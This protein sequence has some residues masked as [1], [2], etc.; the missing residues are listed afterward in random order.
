MSACLIDLKRS[1]GGWNR[2]IFSR[3]FVS[4]LLFVL[5]SYRST[6]PQFMLITQLETHIYRTGKSDMGHMKGDISF[7]VKKVTK[8]KQG[9][10][11]NYIYLLFA[12]A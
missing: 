6:S 1:C 11:I 10:P 12:F 8:V 7:N 3:I 2:T 4:F 5:A 9:L